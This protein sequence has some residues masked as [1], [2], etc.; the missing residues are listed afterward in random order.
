MKA[1]MHFFLNDD[2]SFRSIYQGSGMDLAAMLKRT[3]KDSEVIGP[4]ILLAAT[5]ILEDGGDT[6]LASRI[7]KVIPSYIKE[8]PNGETEPEE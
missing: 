4:V 8:E 5:S 3:A 2:N 6:D 1:Q 7:A